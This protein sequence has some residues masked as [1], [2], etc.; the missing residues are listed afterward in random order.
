MKT[1]E[2]YATASKTTESEGIVSDQNSMEM[3]SGVNPSVVD[4]V[5]TQ[6]LESGI[7][8]SSVE[9]VHVTMADKIK[10]SSAYIVDGTTIPS[11]E[12]FGTFEA[13]PPASTQVLPPTAPRVLA[14]NLSPPP[15]PSPTEPPSHIQKPADVSDGLLSS[16]LSEN[17]EQ[18]NIRSTASLDADVEKNVASYGKNAE[19]SDSNA[20]NLKEAPTESEGSGSWFDSML[21]FVEDKFLTGLEEN[22]T[23][24]GETGF[25]EPKKEDLVSD[26]DDDE[27]EGDTEFDGMYV[28]PEKDTQSSDE[29]TP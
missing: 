18:V 4:Q 17:D 5:Q 21:H 23:L 7:H 2:N 8:S 19:S 9:P 20:D 28:L 6:V 3:P 29:Q 15:P 22:D 25:K 11:D 24:S 16:Q 1:E 27:S 10:P 12:D 13:K 14:A 26:G